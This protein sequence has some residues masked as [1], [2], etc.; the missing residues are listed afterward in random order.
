MCNILVLTVLFSYAAATQIQSDNLHRIIHGDIAADGQFPYAMSLQELGSPQSLNTRGHRCGGVL[1]TLQHALTVASCLYDLVNGYFRIIEPSNYRVFAGPS[2]LTND[3]SPE[4]IRQIANFTVHPEYIGPPAYVNDI[5]I[6]TVI[7][8]FTT[9]AVRP[10]ALPASNFDPSKF[11]SC[12]VTGWGAA[13]STDTASVALRYA[14]KYIYDQEL[15][16]SMFN[17]SPGTVNI[18]PSMVCAASHNIISSGC[19]GDNGNPLVCNNTLTGVLFMTDACR[20]SSYPEL[21]TRVSTYTTW[22]RSVSS[23]PPIFSSGTILLLMTTIAR[24]L[25]P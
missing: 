25:F 17:L 16:M 18:L 3:T 9:V 13:N 11:T 8:P 21:Y 10:L 7:T 15:C 6:I 1:F 12:T 20:S 5:A 24:L 2:A 23:A 14:S 4:F 22:I 19:M